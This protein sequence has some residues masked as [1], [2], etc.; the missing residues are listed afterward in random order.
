MTG[1]YH[2]EC[3]SPVLKLGI[4]GLPHLGAILG[5]LLASYLADN[6]GRKTALVASQTVCT[7]GSLLVV[8]GGNVWMAA[9]G[10]LL[11]GLGA[12]PAA[13]LAFL[14]FCEVV[15]DPLRQ[16]YSVMMQACFPVGGLAAAALLLLFSNWR[17]T[18]ALVVVLPCLLEL[19]LVGC[20]VEETPHFLLKQGCESALAAL[21]RIGVRNQGRGESL[22]EE[23]VESVIDFQQVR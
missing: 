12:L 10:L 14:F 2:L 1:L 18:W 15:N 19:V 4:R 20:Y 17:V 8:F 5:S 16:R 22:E 3:L 9:A 13:T 23:E 7:L 21:N 11:S 6:H